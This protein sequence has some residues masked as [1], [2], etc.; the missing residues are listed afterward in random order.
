[1][2]VTELVTA[3]NVRL[4]HHNLKP[5]PYH[6]KADGAAILDE[7]QRAPPA[8]TEAILQWHWGTTTLTRVRR[9]AQWEEKPQRQAFAREVALTK[10][11]R[12]PSQCDA[13][14]QIDAQT[15]PFP[16]SRSLNETDTT[17]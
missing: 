10:A 15:L 8:Q 9:F 7:I 17:P 4:T 13:A 14:H 5:M 3:I 2:S 11:A 6:W 16:F 1:M 12:A